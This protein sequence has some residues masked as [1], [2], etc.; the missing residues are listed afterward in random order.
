MMVKRKANEEKET[1][2]SSLL[3][4]SQ[5]S[6]T[7]ELIKRLER[8]LKKG[9]FTVITPHTLAQTY[10]I[11]ISTARKLLREAAQKGLVVLYSGGRTPIYIKP[12][13]K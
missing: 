11:R 5:I 6:V 2:M 12:S 8:D 13:M 10:E 9:A 4:E 1:P 3:S 7:K